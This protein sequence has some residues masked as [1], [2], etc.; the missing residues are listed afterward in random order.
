MSGVGED[1]RGKKKCRVLGTAKKFYVDK[2]H[3][4][5]RGICAVREENFA[6]RR[7]K[8][9]TI[10]KILQAFHKLSLVFKH[11]S[12]LYRRVFPITSGAIVYGSSL[13]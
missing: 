5:L 4:M 9:G 6:E 2:G 12:I 7:G 1:G 10:Y 13:F 3:L 11:L 8:E